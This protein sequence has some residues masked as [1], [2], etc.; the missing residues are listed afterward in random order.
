MLAC[1]KFCDPFSFFIRFQIAMFFSSYTLT[2]LP[3]R[4][5]YT[6]DPVNNDSAIARHDF[7]NP[8]YQT[9]DEREEDFEVPRE[10]ARLLEQENKTIQPHEEPI[11]VINL[12]SNE[13]MKEVKIGADL[14]YSVKQRLIQMLRDYVEIFAWSYEDMPGLDTDIVVHRLPI[15][16]GSTPVKQKLRRSRP[17]MSKK[18]KDEVEKQFNAGF[19]KVVSYPPWIANIVPVPAEY[20]ACILG[21]KAA[22][23]LR[24]KF[25]EVYGDSALVIYQVKGEWDTK[26]PN[27]IPY[28]E[29]VLS[30]IPYFEEITFEHIPREEN[31]LA[32]AL[33]TMSSMFKVRWDNEAPMITIYRQDEP[34]YCNEINAEGTEE[35]AW[36]HEVKR[37]LEAQEYPEGASINDRKFLRRFAAKFFLSNGTLYKRNHDSTL[38]RCVNKKEAEQIMEEIHNGAFGTH[39]SGHT[40]AK[41]I[42]RAGYYWSTMETDCHHHS[43]TCHKCQIYADKVHVPPVPLSVLTAPWPFAMWGIDMIGEIKPT[44]SNGHRFILV[45]IDYFIKWV[46]AASFASVTKNVVARFIKYNL[47]CRYGIPERI[48]TDNG[49]NLNNRMITELCTQFKI[50]HHNSSPYRPKMNGAVEAANKN[51][52]K[53][54]Q[55]MKVTYKDWHEMLPFAL[56]GYRTSARTSTGATP[57]SLVYGMEAVLPIEIQI[58][59]LRIMKEA[60]LDEDDWIQTRLDQINLIDEKRLA[61]ICHGQLYQKR[62]IKAFNKKVKSQAYQTGGLVIKRIILPQGDPRGKWTPTYEGPFIIKKIFSG[63]AMLLTTMDGEDFPHPV[64]AD[65][66]KKYFS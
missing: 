12:G 60:N 1:S 50:K 9:E 38:L 28:K 51:I 22:I 4:F 52:K 57:F 41:K 63:G 65:I 37:Y 25:L 16:E 14:E 45:A 10:L 56:H 64:N 49:T 53:I 39:S 20:E 40:M 29:Y 46:E 19:L 55:K 59:S 13:E 24:I 30:L 66:V 34:S 7:E 31:Q 27:L 2:Y 5:T 47:I 48:I 42:L 26:H 15:K 8:I 43:R 61:A 44:A 36:F 6:L 17:D 58:P 54:I 23:D 18:I 35:K 33:A 11:E 21:L 32:D 3:C 62:M